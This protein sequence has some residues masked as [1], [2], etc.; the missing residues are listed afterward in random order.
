MD[1]DNPALDPDYI[2]AGAIRQIEGT[3]MTDAAGNRIGGLLISPQGQTF[4]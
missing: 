4:C 2:G 1:E 3:R